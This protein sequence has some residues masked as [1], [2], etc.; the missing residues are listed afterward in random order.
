[1]SEVVQGNAPPE[2]L[3]LLRKPLLLERHKGGPVL[4]S[5]DDGD[6]CILSWLAGQTNG[7]ACA[8]AI[9]VP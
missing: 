2:D 3:M 1:M 9:G 5:G 6:T 8:N 4:I 7:Q